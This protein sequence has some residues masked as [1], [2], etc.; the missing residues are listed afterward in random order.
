[1]SPLAA[2]AMTGCLAVNPGSDRILA[3]ELAAAIPGLSAP[4]SNDPVSLAPA[5]GVQRIFRVPELRRLALRLHWD[6]E[7]AADIC[8]ERPV[9]PPDP[10]RF[11][12]SMR[13]ALPQA[14]ITILEYGRQ[15]LPA[16]EVEFPANGLRPGCGGGLWIGYVQY[17][18]SRRF[19]LWARVKALVTIPR[20]VAAV[21]LR[22]GEAIA[23]EQVRAETRE[24]FPSAAPF[25]QTP[26]E[27]L[28]KWPRHAIP[29]GTAIRAEMLQNP[30]E[31]MRG[32]PVTVDVYDGAAHLEL[33][34]RAEASGSVGETI[35]VSNPSSHKRFLARVEGKGRVSVGP[36]TTKVNP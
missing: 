36:S 35:P 33:E 7:P 10:A 24:E 28:G 30:K 27:A 3:S 19:A 15:P 8:I 34:A 12:E 14:D 5:P 21:D 26:S 13:K 2:L 22:P 20:L 32:D 9:S 29:S 1:M 4:F 6:V 18:G 17:A 25:L 16:G 23:A 11:L 31:V